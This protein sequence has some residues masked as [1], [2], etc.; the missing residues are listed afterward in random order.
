MRVLVGSDNTI[1]SPVFVGPDGETP[2]A[3]TGLPVVAVSRAVGT[4]LTVPVAVSVSTGVYSTVLTAAAHTAI[5]DRLTVTWTGTAGGRV[6]TYSTTVEVVGSHYV[7]IPELRALPG[8]GSSS[9]VATARLLEA[10]DEFADIAEDYRGVSYVPRY[11]LETIKEGYAYPYGF[12]RGSR[13][14]LRHI[15][16]RVI[17]T[18]TLAGVAVTDLT[19]VAF[20][21]AG[22]LDW[23]YA[24]ATVPVS[25]TGIPR[26][27]VVGYEHGYDNPPEAVRRACRQY[28][29]STLLGDTS[30][31]PRDIVYQSMDGMTTRYSSPDK[32]A[33]RPTGYIEVDR[34]LNSVIDERVPA[35][36]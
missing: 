15:R 35:F 29:R 19:T 32:A 12:L 5:L 22:S 14:F 16:P 17:R 36:A 3:T 4:V 25:I 27:I 31:V 9:G 34:L 1:T 28:V 2:T 24:S 10:R 18:L 6:Q 7:T 11:H 20:T 8:L 13:T 26:D 21:L 30:G 33:G 23:S